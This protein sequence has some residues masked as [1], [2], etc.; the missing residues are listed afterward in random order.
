MLL[1]P[2]IERELRAQARRPFTFWGR[3]LT[4]VIATFIF[5]T[6]TERRYRLPSD[7]G[8][9]VFMGLHLCFLAFLWVGVPL[10]ICDVIA[11]E[12]REGTLGLLFL[13]PLTP[14]AIVLGKIFAH[15]W[16]SL[17]VL[18]AALP[19]MAVPVILGGVKWIDYL[20]SLS[21]LLTALLLAIS[22]GLLASS[23]AERRG[24]VTTAAA[25][26]ALVLFGFQIFVTGWMHFQVGKMHIP[27]TGQYFPMGCGFFETFGIGIIQISD[28]GRN[29]FLDPWT[30]FSRNIPSQVL[31]FR[32]GLVLGS[33]MVGL[34]TA[35]LVVLFAIRQVAK[36]RSEREISPLKLRLSAL[37]ETPVLFT[38]YFQKRMRLVIGKNPIAWLQQYSW[39]S[40]I[41][42]WTWCLLVILAETMLLSLM[43]G[44]IKNPYQYNG[45][46]NDELALGVNILLALGILLTF[47]A[48]AASSF[49]REKELGILEI[50]LISPLPVRKIIS[51]R[52]WGL[53][54]QFFPGFILLTLSSI[55]VFDERFIGFS[56]HAEWRWWLLTAWG[57]FFVFPFAGLY[58]SLRLK[59]F[60]PA[61]IA[62]CIGTL[63]PWLFGTLSA[64]LAAEALRSLYGNDASW[65]WLVAD[66]LDQMIYV[67]TS[68]S[69]FSLAFAA[70]SCFLL[71]H[72]LSRRIYP[73]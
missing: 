43:V 35:L 31:N 54:M 8:H 14:T 48:V 18:L 25:I 66:N 37:L 49:L 70:L 13:T 34:T 58:F 1:W 64:N 9:N 39:R 32:L 26:A 51:G 6:L 56:L 23:I 68:V 33:T 42:K 60:V 20:N 5:Y 41:I 21:Y 63:L 52:I 45:I 29:I 47:G 50:L 69:G 57:F 11:R 40:R 7:M 61:W 59:R 44:D 71:H 2:V 72:S 30:S 27:T 36:S 73:M 67:I 53:W 12:K 28:P 24:M 22:A 62:T 17:S 4:G 46:S 65:D 38:G 15:A 16:R 3:V 55:I 19:I 10:M